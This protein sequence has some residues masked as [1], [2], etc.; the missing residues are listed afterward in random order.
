MLA[1]LAVC[2]A[3]PALAQDSYPYFGAS[4]GK[5]RANLDEQ[6]ISNSLIGPGQTASVVS[7]SPKSTGYKVFLGY[8]M[9]R[10]FALEVGYFHLGKFGFSDKTTPAG[11]L[12][13]Q[14]RVQGANADL[15]GLLPIGDSFALLGRAGAQ[16]A[17]TRDEFTTTGTATTTNPH[18]TSRG[19]GYKVGVGMQYA[20]SPSVLMRLEGERYRINDAMGHKINTNLYSVGLVVPFGRSERTAPRMA[21]SEPY[22]APRPAPEPRAMAPMPPPA[23]MVAQ[24]PV[25]PS[26][27]MPQAQRVS[28]SAESLFGF[29]RSE[30][31]PEGR[32]ALDGFVQQMQ[33]TRFETVIVEGHTDRLG[34]TE[35]NQ[36]LSQRRADAVKAYLV[37]SGRLDPAKVSAVGRSESTPVTKPEDCKGTHQTAAL[38]ACLQPDRR[39]EIVVTGTR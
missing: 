3:G 36:T 10:N 20:F 8:Q 38:V 18:P 6:G 21:M 26:P 28:F 1:A 39:V 13:G 2:T 24:A 32:S 30:L 16:Y 9:N 37:D 31:R 25:A 15:V 14:V 35:Y 12:D 29:D 11:S 4:V 27:P 33:G 22:V 5:A 7:T 19:A 17:R 23:P 34:S